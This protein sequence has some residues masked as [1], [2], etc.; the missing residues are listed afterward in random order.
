MKETLITQKEGLNE[1]LIE[2]L[3]DNLKE[4]KTVSIRQ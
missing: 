3:E 4:L 1:E 2:S